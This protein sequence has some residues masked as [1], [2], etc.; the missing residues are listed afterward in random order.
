MHVAAASEHA[1]AE[2]VEHRE[3]QAHGEEHEVEACVVA[4]VLASA[5]PMGQVA[6]DAYADAAEHEG[7]QNAGE[8]TLS[9]Y[10]S[11]SGKVAGT[12]PVRHLDV[13]AHASRRAETAEEPY[14]GADQSDAGTGVCAE[15]AHHARIDVLHHDVHQLGHHAGETEQ[16]GKE[17]LVLTSYLCSIPNFRKE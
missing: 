2:R 11:C 10:L 5:Q 4:D 8:E 1:G 9:E 12:Y 17:Y 13:E 16:G 15:A 3:G 6:A 14:R 7:K